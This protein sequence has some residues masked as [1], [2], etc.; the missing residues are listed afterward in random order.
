MPVWPPI[1]QSGSTTPLARAA[2]LLFGAI[3]VVALLAAGWSLPFESPKLAAGNGRPNEEIAPELPSTSTRHQDAPSPG[4][5]IGTRPH[6]QAGPVREAHAQGVQ[7]HFVPKPT[8][9]MPAVNATSGQRVRVAVH[10]E[11]SA[12]SIAAFQVTVSG[13][14]RGARLVRGVQEAPDRWLIPAANLG[15]LELVLGDD[16][17][18]GRFELAWELRGID[19]RPITETKSVL[20]VAPVADGSG[21]RASPAPTEPTAAP[22]GPV[23]AVKAT[24]GATSGRNAVSGDGERA[25]EANRDRLLIRGLRML[26]LGS[27]NSARLLFRRAADAGDARAALVLGDTFDGVRL[28]QLGVLGVQP[29]HAQAVYWYERA[30][31]LGAP[32]AKQRLSDLNAR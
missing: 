20:V 9:T 19:G 27:V 13:L 28:V 31:E 15:V 11:P 25:D 30:D 5:D 4:G 8:L 18:P 3:T 29:D 24:P 17:A 10:I 1:G 16:T 23:P 26:V 7:P 32:E 2:Q 6:I 12:F 21:A 14:P 22:G